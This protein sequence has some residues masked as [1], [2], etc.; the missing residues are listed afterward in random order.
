MSTGDTTIEGDV[1]FN[2]NRTQIKNS[3][4]TTLFDIDIANTAVNIDMDL[5]VSNNV[6]F[7][8]SIT[9]NIDNS[10]NV[11]VFKVVGASGNTTIG[12]TLDVTGIVKPK[13]HN[14]KHKQHSTGALDCRRWRRHC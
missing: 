6:T 11:N 12:G 8:N 13:Q 7:D 1:V 9:F 10:S 3:S 14:T 5:T 2:D 4:N